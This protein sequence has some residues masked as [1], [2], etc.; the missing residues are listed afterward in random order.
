[1]VKDEK[2]SCLFFKKKQ[3]KTM[4]VRH[5]KTATYAS[6]KITYLSQLKIALVSI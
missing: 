4:S 5:I 6:I 3:N 2:Y 1:M